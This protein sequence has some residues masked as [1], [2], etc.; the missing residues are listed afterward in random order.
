MTST[1]I[2]GHTQEMNNA[3]ALTV[4]MNFP[5]APHT[6]TLTITPELAEAWLGRNRKNRIISRF[7]VLKY[8]RDINK[9]TWRLTGEPVKFDYNGV[10]LDG[11]HRMLAII[12]AQRPITTDVRFG[13]EP[14]VFINIDTGQKRSGADFLAIAGEVCCSM[15][16]AALSNLLN[17]ERG[18]YTRLGKRSYTNDEIAEM[19]ERHPTVRDSIP[20]GRM[21]ELLLPPSLGT[22]LHYLAAN[23]DKEKADLFWEQLQNG[24]GLTLTSPVRMLRERLST[25]RALS[26]KRGRAHSTEL[27]A[28]T[29]KAFNSFVQNKPVRLL[30]WASQG[31]KTEEFPVFDM[32]GG[33]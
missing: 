9:G 22:A 2:N 4:A 1:S 27:A 25:D 7:N 6:V 26:R 8:A 30:R 23:V 17:Y 24:V 15:L 33:R 14:E 21:T 5:T 29:I 32:R 28:I 10:M 13:L 11:Q 3:A 12:E 16:S 19:L 31:K 18:W 20:F